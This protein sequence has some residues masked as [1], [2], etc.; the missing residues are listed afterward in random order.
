MRVNKMMNKWVLWRITIY[1]RYIR[2]KIIWDI[3]YIRVVTWELWWSLKNQVREKR[4]I[5]ERI[6]VRLLGRK[7]R[8][9]VRVRERERNK[10]VKKKVICLA[11]NERSCNPNKSMVMFEQKHLLIKSYFGFWFINQTQTISF[12]DFHYFL[13]L[14]LSLSFHHTFLFRTS[15]TFSERK[16]L[17]LS[18]SLFPPHFST[19]SLLHSTFHSY[20]QN[21]HFIGFS[22]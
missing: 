13:S 9:S 4:I 22:D 19:S 12:Q 2:Y 20:V 6:P 5:V 11:R 18:L 7:V 17:S 3:R 15:T 14:P 16:L 8:K 10:D 21:T 1:K